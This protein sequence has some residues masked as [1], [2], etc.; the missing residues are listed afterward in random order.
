MFAKTG[1]MRS[2]ST[3]RNSAK[4]ARNLLGRVQS[5]NVVGHAE[6]ERVSR[7]HR[8]GPMTYILDADGI[9]NQSK[10]RAIKSVFR[11]NQNAP[12]NAKTE[13]FVEPKAQPSGFYLNPFQSSQFDKIVEKNAQREQQVNSREDGRENHY[14]KAIGIPEKAVKPGPA[15]YAFTDPWIPENSRSGQLKNLREKVQARSAR[16][17]N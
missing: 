6:S 2:M 13:R 7:E 14:L 9:G 3:G 4:R 16:Q 12:F 8:P 15:D 17:K 11:S 1:T 10:Q 5:Q